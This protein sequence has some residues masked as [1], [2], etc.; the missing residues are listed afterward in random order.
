MEA[1]KSGRSLNSEIVHRLTISLSMPATLSSD[2][3]TGASSSDLIASTAAQLATPE[4]RAKLEQ[5]LG[6][7]LSAAQ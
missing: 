3:Q 2:M 5:I 7:I 6:I 1:E 4:N